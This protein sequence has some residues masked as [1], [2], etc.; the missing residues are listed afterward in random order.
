MKRLSVLLL[1][2]ALLTVL[3]AGAL[4]EDTLREAAAS[5]KTLV[6]TEAEVPAPEDP[7]SLLIGLSP[8]GKTALY[9]TDDGLTL[10]RDG[11][12]L[13][14][15]IAPERGAGDPYGKLAWET[16]TVLRSF[17]DSAGLS[18]SPDGHFVLLTNMD[19]VVRRLTALDLI[20]LDTE[21]G[22]IFLEQAFEG[23]SQERGDFLESLHSP[24]FGMIVEARF[25]RTGRYIYMIGRINAL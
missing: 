19:A 3:A 22:E 18:W 12:V 15:H 5:G 1:C 7:Y 8:D 13:Q 11:Q 16:Q 14:A 24:D 20:L 21:T 9:R 10:V 2:A 4:A 17:P 6:L 25:D 23:G